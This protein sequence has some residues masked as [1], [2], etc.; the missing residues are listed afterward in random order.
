MHTERR[1]NERKK[2]TATDKSLLFLH[3]NSH[4]LDIF[5]PSFYCSSSETSSQGSYKMSPQE[6]RLPR[7]MP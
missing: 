5:I 7:V 1:E 3:F 4:Q 2:D 6:Q